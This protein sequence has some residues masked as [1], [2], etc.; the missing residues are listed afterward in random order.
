MKEKFMD[1]LLSALVPYLKEDTI[2][3]AK[4][5]LTVIC[6]GYDISICET[7]VIP[8]EGDKNEIILKKYIMAKISRGLSNRT[9]KYYATSLKFVFE[10]LGK[11]FD[12]VQPEDIRLYLAMRIKKDGVSKTT[13]NN[14][15]RNLS[16]FYTWAQKEEILMKNPM[17]KVEAVKEDKKKKNA[18]SKMDLEL[19]RA[20]CMT[21]EERAIIELLISTWSR[22]SEIA[23]IQRSEISGNRILIHGKGSKD[24]YVYLSAK[25]Q[26][27][28]NSY[29]SK[30][31]DSNPYL[32]PRAKYAGDLNKWP[33]GRGARKTWYEIPELVDDTRH[34]DAG[35]IESKIRR[36]GKKADVTNAHPHRFRR[37]GATMAL[38]AGMPLVTVSKLLG[39]ANIGVT[40]V[41]LDISDQELEQAHQKYVE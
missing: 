15:R 27:A 35:T 17:A 3:D 36:I 5:A 19:M 40:Q 18:F 20:N 33:K 24:R 10:R 26:L 11:P 8:Y 30:R 37:T 21:D 28:L 6:G 2:S 39:H 12:E 4:M 23:Q 16:A 7:S 22:V 9:V 38:R 34:I 29:L 13:A 14:E 31:K 32:F 41:Y 1:E 25:A